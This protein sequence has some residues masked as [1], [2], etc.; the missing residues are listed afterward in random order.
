MAAR[1]PPKSA[2]RV[3]S[4]ANPLLRASTQFRSS[5]SPRCV[6]GETW[7]CDIAAEDRARHKA[8]AGLTNLPPPAMQLEHACQENVGSRMRECFASRVEAE[9]G[10]ILRNTHGIAAVCHAIPSRTSQQ[11]ANRGPTGGTRVR[12]HPQRGRHWRPPAK[13]AASNARGRFVEVSR[14]C[15]VMA[16]SPMLG[17]AILKGALVGSRVRRQ[18]QLPSG[19]AL[20]VLVNLTETRSS[21]QHK[22]RRATR[23]AS[24]E[25]V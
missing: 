22:L 18:A 19:V 15:T 7:R 2:L 12:F 1:R 11:G 10:N 20:P 3:K 25:L 16:L 23:L 17:A 5:L 4:V 13:D 24:L 14:Y 8:G 21:K 6:R 9:T